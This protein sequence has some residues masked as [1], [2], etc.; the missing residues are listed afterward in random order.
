MTQN[1]AAKQRKIQFCEPLG[2][3][4]FARSLKAKDRSL[5]DCWETST[6]VAIAAAS[7]SS[8]PTKV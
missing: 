6:P 8:E 1:A 2:S 7:I 5:P 4:T 3:V